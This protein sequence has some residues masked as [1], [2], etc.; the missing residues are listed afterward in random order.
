MA[1]D[2]PPG[3]CLHHHV[4]PRV[5]GASEPRRVDRQDGEGKVWSFTAPCV[6]HDDRKPSL[7]ISEGDY[8]RF[9]WYCHAGCSERKIR[10]ALIKAKVPRECLPRSAA[11]LRDLE[12]SLFALLTS[13]LSHAD[14]RLRALALLDS[15]DG[16]LPRGTALAEL[17]AAAHVSRSGAFRA[18]GSAAPGTTQ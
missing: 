5:P 14:V 10:H 11:E 1:C 15:P 3:E 12:E 7:T 8:R 16:K 18:L 17:A 6:A 4:W 13:D 9:V 2:A